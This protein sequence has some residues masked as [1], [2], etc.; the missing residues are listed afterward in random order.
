MP[1]ALRSRLSLRQRQTTNPATST[2]ATAAII[3]RADMEPQGMSAQLAR[4]R[5]RDRGG[6]LLCGAPVREEA[7]AGGPRAAHGG[8]EGAGGAE[9][10]EL[11]LEIGSQRERGLLEVVLERGGELGWVRPREPAQRARVELGAPATETVQLGI[12][13]SGGEAVGVRDQEHCHPREDKRLHALADAMDEC[14]ARVDLAGHIRAQVGREAQQLLAAE[15]PPGELVGDAQSR[16][17]VRTSTAEAGGHGDA[18]VDPQ[19]ERRQVDTRASAEL[20]ERERREVL[21]GHA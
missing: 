6:G 15:R 19:F 21:G 9:R 10:F 16:G 13:R 2:A 8:A 11:L 3:S 20:C 18:L 7:E 12:N 1:I 17:R 14:V 5:S 4:E